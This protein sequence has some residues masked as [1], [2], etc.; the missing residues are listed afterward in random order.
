VGQ[1]IGGGCFES[2]SGTKI[3]GTV[4]RVEVGCFEGRK[5]G[6]LYTKKE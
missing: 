6:Y 4:L 3:E 2:K 1:K 5:C